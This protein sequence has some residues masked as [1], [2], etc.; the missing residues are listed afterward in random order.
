MQGADFREFILAA[1][2]WTASLIGSRAIKGLLLAGY[3]ACALAAS[4]ADSLVDLFAVMTDRAEE[5]PPLQA[6]EAV[7]LLSAF[8]LLVGR[9]VLG[10][11]R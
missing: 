11:L 7:T 10:A 1:I 6:V 4:A 2:Q 9:G 8:V 3:L 5:H